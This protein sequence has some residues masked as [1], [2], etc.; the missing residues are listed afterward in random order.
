[1]ARY[2]PYNTSQLVMVAIDFE[3]QLVPGTF[4]YALHMLIEDKL[5]LSGFDACYRND[6][7]GAP[8]YDPAI[9]LKIILYAYSKGITSS[10]RIEQ[11]CREHVVFM[12]LAAHGVPHFTTIADFVATRQAAIERLFRDVLLVCEQ[13][14]LI[15]REMFAVDGVK[16][17]SNASKEYPISEFSTTLIASLAPGCAARSIVACTLLHLDMT[18]TQRKRGRL[19]STC[20]LGLAASGFGS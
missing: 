20:G 7:T 6:A 15:G 1:M 5:D 4:E 18:K 11:L 17:P 3:H 10:R 19:E 12:A 13:A 14:G 16:L 2:K 9:L 8:A